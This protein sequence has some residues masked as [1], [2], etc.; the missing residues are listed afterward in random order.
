M[1]KLILVDEKDSVIG[2]EEK[3]R[4]HDGDGILHR[5]F[6]VFIFNDKGKL[7]VQQRSG[8][9]RLWPL[10]WSNSCCSHPRQDEDCKKAAERRVMEELGISSELKLLYK[11]QYKAKYKD[12][13]S[14]NELCAVLIGRSG[15]PVVLDK[16]EV[17][18]YKWIKMSELVEEI[19]QHPDMFSPWFKLEIKELLSGYKER[20]DSL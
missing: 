18:D 7:L 10:F 16:E 4:C 6:S 20:I 13:G 17:A 2:T 3:E 19:E 11:F 14:E 1:D 5:A 9:K 15:H 8:L 12:K